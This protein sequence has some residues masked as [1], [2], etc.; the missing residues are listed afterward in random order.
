MTSSLANGA[1][2]A[3]RLVEANFAGL[4]PATR[5]VLWAAGLAALLALLLTSPVRAQTGCPCGSCPAHRPALP[6]ISSAASNARFFVRLRFFDS[7][8]VTLTGPDGAPVPFALEAVGEPAGQTFWI[9]PSAP[10]APGAH[11]LTA[12]ATQGFVERQ[13]FGVGRG[14]DITPPSIRGLRIGPP[15]EDR[16]YCGELIGGWLTWDNAWDGAP[17]EDSPLT[18]EV[19]L[20]RGGVVLGTVFPARPRTESEPTEF[21]TSSNADCFAAAHISGLQEGEELT[22]RVRVW[23]SAGNS[24]ELSPVTFVVAREPAA[25]RC[26][27]RCAATPG[28]GSP[29][30][31]FAAVLWLALLYARRRSRRRA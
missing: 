23:D 5:R 31:A 27:S 3:A 13:A 19:E 11:E 9:V 21:G 10:L 24:T 26:P 30:R 2:L 15:G 1:R 16:H 17:W 29:S 6:P 12:T 22:A 20:S 28:L 8:S 18:L 14:E 25:P 4:S 7:S